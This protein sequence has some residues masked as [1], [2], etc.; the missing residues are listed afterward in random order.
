[1]LDKQNLSGILNTENQR[2][3]KTMDID[4]FMKHKE[5]LTAALA[6]AIENTLIDM[7]EDAK[8]ISWFSSIAHNHPKNN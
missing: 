3:V 7:G 1:M 6:N 8:G 2:E 5:S 4:D